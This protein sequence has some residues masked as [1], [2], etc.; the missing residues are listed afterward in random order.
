MAKKK[1]EVIRVSNLANTLDHI[2]N[3]F[4]SIGGNQQ[5]MAEI[6]IN[7]IRRSYGIPVDG[8]QLELF[9]DK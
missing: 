1:P 7:A 2:Q 6:V 5:K 4:K 8:E 3:V 9:E